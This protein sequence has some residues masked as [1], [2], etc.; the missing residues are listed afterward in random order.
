MAATERPTSPRPPV[1]SARA[2]TPESAS[3]TPAPTRS[4]GLSP[5]RPFVRPGVHTMAT[6]VAMIVAGIMMASP[7]HRPTALATTRTA[8][9][10][11]A[12]ASSRRRSE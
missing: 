1:R 6:A 8:N 11:A 5:P 9:V 4:S 12:M 7:G 3:T 2:T 10:A